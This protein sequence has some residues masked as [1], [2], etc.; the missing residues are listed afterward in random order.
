[1]TSPIC[2]S[3]HEIVQFFKKHAHIQ[4]EDVLLHYIQ[5]FEKCGDQMKQNHLLAMIKGLSSKIDG[6]GTHIEQ[7]IVN[8]NKTQNEVLQKLFCECVKDS[9]LT[10]VINEVK[11]LGVLQTLQFDQLSKLVECTQ[12]KLDAFP[13][14]VL[15]ASIENLRTTKLHVEF[16]ELKS[17]MFEQFID[18][19]RS[20]LSN[21]HIDD[22]VEMRRT[23]EN[24]I[25]QESSQT[26]IVKTY[27]CDIDKALSRVTVDITKVE[28]RV[29]K[30]R[31]DQNELLRSYTDNVMQKVIDNEKDLAFIKDTLHEILLLKTGLTSLSATMEAFVKPTRSSAKG[32]LTET[33][34]ES[35]FERLFP[36]HT[37]ERVSSSKQKGNMD[38]QLHKTGQPSIMIDV[39][40]Y[41]KPVPAKE[42][43]KFHADMALGKR[44]S[45]LLCIDCQ[46][47]DKSH[48]EIEITSDHCIAVYLNK[49]SF[50]DMNDVVRA[51]NVIY[52][53]HGILDRYKSSNSSL[54]CAQVQHANTIIKSHMDNIRVVKNNLTQSILLLDSMLSSGLST[55]LQVTAP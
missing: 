23:L 48:F 22:V 33:L 45:I 46:V 7:T 1:M 14:P 42:I 9:L 13:F 21:M 20:R 52:T 12:E 44:H 47:K 2:I 41:S 6:L 3:H 18:H 11:N 26:E 40:K 24:V 27:F 38:L 43:E 10:S 34:T 28:D 25:G 49:V 32:A 51:V 15:L 17:W 50:Q 37:I 39:K 4:V 54:S 35:I 5:F 16:D 53:L 30:G 8:E 29:D 55:A 31:S 36:S 19:L